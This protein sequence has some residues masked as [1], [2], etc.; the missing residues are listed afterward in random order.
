MKAV[1]FIQAPDNG[2]VK[3]GYSANL[4]HRLRELQNYSPVQLTLIRLVRGASRS[5]ETQVLC[6]FAELRT[7]GDWFK[8]HPSM[9]TATADTLGRPIGQITRHGRYICVAGCPFCIEQRKAA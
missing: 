5:F 4:H 2:L 3:I 8:F 6:H 1:Y 9:L 7:H